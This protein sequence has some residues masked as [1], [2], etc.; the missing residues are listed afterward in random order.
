MHATRH[1]R[2][3]IAAALAALLVA[4][5]APAQDGAE[6]GATPP[7]PT[8]GTREGPDVGRE[9]MWTAP[10]AEDWAQPCLITFQRT[11]EDALAIAQE[12]RKAILVCINMD[13]E[14]ASEHYAGVRYRQPEVAALYEPYVCVIA[15]VYRHTPR[16]HDDAG[17]R[18]L[19]PRFGSVTCGE[20][21]AIEPIMFE[22]YLDGRRIAPRHI[23]VELDQSEVYDVYYKNDTASVFDA[24]RGGIETRNV[25][26]RDIV[27]GDRPV[28]ERV[29]GRH[30]ADREAVE[31]AYRAGDEATRRRLL[32]AALANQDA[33]PVDLLRLAVFGFDTELAA[34]ARKALASTDAPE[35]VN[36]IAEALRVPMETA[37]RE[38][39]IAALERMGESSR[40]AW[41]LAVV[42]RGL[43]GKSDAV[44]VA[45]WSQAL[46]GSAA[47]GGATY[48]ESAAERPEVSA[49]WLALETEQARREAACAAEAA[50]GDAHAALAETSLEMACKAQRTFLDSPRFA[51]LFERH[52]F[53]LAARSVERAAE[54]GSKDW[55]VDGVRALVQY[56]TGDAQ[57]AYA[58]AAP[59]VKA[60]PPGEPSWT[61]MALITVFAESR[62]K[63]IKG[64][65]Q[66]RQKWPSEWLTDLDAAYSVLLQHPL[67][68]DGQ[69]AW[70]YDFLLWLRAHRRASRVLDKGLARFPNSSVLHNRFRDSVLAREGVDGLEA[71]YAKLLE[72]A[73]RARD[74]EWFA[75]YA[76]MVAADYHRRGGRAQQAFEAYGRAVPLFEGA[77]ER[78]PAS[79]DSAHRYVAFA[80][81][82]RARM[83]YQ[84]GDVDAALRDVLASFARDTDAAGAR[85][86]VGVTPVETAQIVLAK[87]RVDGRTDE[88]ATLE[89][90]LS[91]LPPEYLLPDRP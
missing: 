47:G 68:T 33:A 12:T 2:S 20:H 30:V 63:S 51:K 24:I 26:T 70:H 77:V 64:A 27:R 10:T 34:S 45:G 8:L 3:V 90:A 13:G 78:N 18:I 49:E 11:W 52:N 56:Y 57:A 1:R 14:I 50:D 22:K 85:D 73:D 80:L 91:E 41:W 87:L 79:A 7:P 40:K 16:D 65:V 83:A 28:V 66:E 82:G 21:I 86:G 69:V 89:K 35:A 39:L 75:G 88:A 42:N 15:S 5:P 48:G 54:L 23:M 58:R 72:G 38:A 32:D 29:A 43:G 25:E 55:R 81:A 59:A 46:A 9:Q 71:A 37:E 84:V 67:G 76:T 62:F 60:M 19:C 53:D 17:N 4:A 61:A 6:G 44:D 74:V 36:L 31:S